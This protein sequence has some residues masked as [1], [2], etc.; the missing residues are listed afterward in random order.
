M[1]INWTEIGT[2]ALNWTQE[3]APAVIGVLVALFVA[4]I[5][6]G[7]VKRGMIR[8]FEK[9]KFDK[10][11]GKFF[12]NA[13][14]WLILI[15]ALLGCLGVFGVDTT[16]FAAVIGAAGLAIGLAFQ[17]TLA[18]FAAGVMLLV[19]RPFKVDDLVQIGG[20]TGVV[21][22]I[23][24]FTTE[25]CTPHNLKVIIPNSSIFGATITNY[26]HHGSRRIDIDVGAD[27][28]ADIDETRKVLEAAVAKLENALEEPAPDVFLKGLGG[29]SVDWVVRAH[30]TN[31][32]YWDLHQELVRAAKVSLDAAGIGIPFP[33][34]DVHIDGAIGKDAA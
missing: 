6:A 14:R 25:L 24:L 8:G 3:K 33:Q 26:T 13:A 31:D 10:T 30:C 22:E 21:V 20:T 11:L 17:G 1:D 18:N 34:M 9:A 32:K 4:W 2:D 29:S 16:S 7:M 19:F 28:S 15:A 23:E 5:I 27:Y 12:A